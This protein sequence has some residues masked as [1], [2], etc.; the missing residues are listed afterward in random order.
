MGDAFSVHRFCVLVAV[1]FGIELVGWAGSAALQTEKFYDLIGALTYWALVIPA[2]GFA[3]GGGRILDDAA[4]TRQR[5][6]A[7]MVLLWSLRLGTFLARRAHKY[8]D[9]RFDEAKCSPGI[10]FVFWMVQGLWCLLTP[11]PGYLLLTQTTKDIVPLGAVEYISWSFWLLGFCIEVVADCQKSAWKDARNTSFIQSGLW[12]YSQ[13]PNYFGEMLLWVAY[14]VPCTRAL[15]GWGAKIAS[16]V[17]PIFVVL[18]LR[19]VSGVPLLQKSA[20]EKYGNDPSFK[21]YSAGTSLLIPW[22]PSTINDE[23]IAPS[24]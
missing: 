9:R 3:H 11:L 20:M 23:E 15:K 18:L 22:F 7:L 6:A 13:H 10:F 21:A 2:Y 5:V 19:Y 8:G 24:E 16:M 4:S 14:C 12:R 1:D 17:S